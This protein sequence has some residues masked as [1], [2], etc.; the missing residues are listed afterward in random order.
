MSTI[1]FSLLIEAAYKFGPSK[2][3]KI[4]EVK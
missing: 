3:K 1:F 4:S 2:I